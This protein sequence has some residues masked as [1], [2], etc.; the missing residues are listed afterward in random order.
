MKELQR[1]MMINGMLVILIAMLAGF[2]LLF[3]LVGGLE[4]WPGHIIELP[5]YGT[6]EGWVRAHT[7]GILN[8]LLVMVVALS[9]PMLELSELKNKFM[10]YGFSYAAWSFTLFYWIGNAVANRALTLG[11][12][13]L[14]ESSFLS[15][16]GFLPGLPSVLV[17]VVLLAIGI[18]SLLGRPKND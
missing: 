18:N 5:S 7:G 16:L 6:T 11:D 1:I 14:G 15:V 9:L 17:V 12:N 13:P 2:M 3:Q 8:G 4:V 10:A